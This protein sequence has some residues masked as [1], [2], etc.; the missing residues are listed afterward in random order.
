M[1]LCN[2]WRIGGLCEEKEPTLISG[3]WEGRK[4]LCFSQWKLGAGPVGTG[5]IVGLGLLGIHLSRLE[6]AEAG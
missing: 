4:A 5:V 1:S 6:V 3:G 2:D